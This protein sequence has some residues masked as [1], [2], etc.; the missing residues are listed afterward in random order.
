MG[1]SWN[2]AALGEL[3]SFANGRSSPERDERF[4]HPVYGSNGLI[5]YS[6]ETNADPD[7]IIIGRV[8][9]YCGSLHYSSDDCWVTDNAIRA[10]AI[11]D[12]DSRFLYYLLQTLSLNDWRAG[13]GQPLL[14]QTTLASIP[15]RVPP[16]HEQ[17]AI[18]GFLGALDE[19][20]DL[21][22][23]MN[24]TMDAIARGLFKSW[25]V[26]FDPVHAKR[27]R[28]HHPQPDKKFLSLFPESFDR[29]GTPQGWSTKPLSGIAEFLNGLAMQRF[30][31]ISSSNSLPVIKV[32]ELRSGVT[33]KTGRAS[34][35][36]PAKYVVRDGDFLFSWSGS[37]IAK[38]W[39][40][41]EG[42]LNQ[43]LFKV[44]SGRYPMW[45]CGHW[46][47]HHLEGFQAIAA[48]KATTMGHIQRR[49]LKQAM[50]TCPPDG[51]LAELGH[52]ME[53]LVDRVIKNELESRTL[54]EIRDR[55]LS[56]LI[57]GELRI[58]SAVNGREDA[59]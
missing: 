15:V 34:R 23:H 9:S 14:N 7:T 51:V 24:E 32:S 37:L 55:L 39:T 3:L 56:K 58:L 42:A 31:A 44:T 11:E 21:N 43:H 35:G 6:E 26:D 13:S 45:F 28:S 12:N 53:N 33:P 36:M 52:I 29:H 30:P 49:H 50:A 18:A 8:G 47:Y 17:R 4:S 19:K 2:D 59:T 1:R 54:V 46:I 10:T 40:G 41:G 5:G 25:F 16:S 48:S 38:F 27:V 20:I 57:T 22:R